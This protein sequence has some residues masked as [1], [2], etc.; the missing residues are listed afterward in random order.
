[1]IGENSIDYLLVDC[2]FMSKVDKESI[3]VLD[4]QIKNLE[5]VVMKSHTYDQ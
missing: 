4:K 1:M 3:K 2:Q 5:F